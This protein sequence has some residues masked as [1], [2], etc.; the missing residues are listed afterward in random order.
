MSSEEL[1]NYRNEVINKLK[2]QAVDRVNE[3][4]KNKFTGPKAWQELIKNP[5]YYNKLGGLIQA[6]KGKTVKSKDGTVTNT[7]TKANGDT[8]IQVKTKNGKYYEKLIKK[9]DALDTLSKLQGAIKPEFLA[10]GNAEAKTKKEEK[11][12]KQKFLKEAWSNYDDWST[13][14]KVSDRVG[15]FLND[16]F[17]MTARALTGDQAYIPG[18]AQG[19]HNHEDPEVRNRYLK[20]LGYTPGEFDASDV[21]NMINPGYW[22]SSFVENSRKGNVG[23]AALEGALMFLPHLPKGT[24]SKSNIRSGANML[25]NDVAKEYNKVA[26]GNSF[27]TDMGVPAWKIEK[28]NQS[29]FGTGKDLR[30]YIAKNAT[31]R[32]AELYT[33]FGQGMHNLTPEDWAEFEAL[34]K[35]GATDFS[36][37]NTPISRIPL[38]YNSSEKAWDEARKLLNLKRGQ[39]YKTPSNKSIRTWSAGIPEGYSAERIARSKPE[40]KIRLVI[41]SR[42]TKNLGNEFA[43]MPYHDPKVKF[44]Y[45]E[46]GTINL[47]AASENELM[48][49][50]PGGFKVIGKSAEDGMNNLIIKPVNNSNLFSNILGKLNKKKGYNE[51][52]KQLFGSDNFSNGVNK[53]ID[54]IPYKPELNTNAAS[55]LY[56]VVHERKLLFDTPEGKRRIQEIIDNTP[57]IKNAGITVDDYKKGLDEI[58]NVNVHYHNLYKKYDDL[59]KALN[60]GKS[61]PGADLQALNDMNSQLGKMA[62]ELG[63]YEEFIHKPKWYLNA[64]LQ[65]EQ[66]KQNALNI[67][68]SVEH[69]ML[70][71]NDKFQIFTSPWLSDDDILRIGRHEIGHY[72]QRGVKTNLD[73]ELEKITLLESNPAIKQIPAGQEK[74]S[75]EFY[76]KILSKEDPFYSMKKYWKTGSKGRETVPFMEEVRADLLEEGMINNLYDEVTTEMLEYHYTNYLKKQGNKYPLRIFDIMENKPENFKIMSDVINKMPAIAPIVG[77]AGAAAI[78]GNEQGQKKEM[79]KGG[80]VADLTEKEIREY[81]ARGYIVEEDD[82]EYQD[83]GE[84]EAISNIRRRQKEIADLRA[85]SNMSEEVNQTSTQAPVQKTIVINKEPIKPLVRIA[86]SN[87]QIE[88]PKS[89]VVNKPIVK[90]FEKSK[91]KAEQKLNQKQIIHQVQAIKK[92]LKASYLPNAPKEFYNQFVEKPVTKHVQTPK[93]L[94]SDN[95]TYAD[96]LKRMMRAIEEDDMM[97]LVSGTEP[98]PKPLFENS[99]IEKEILDRQK[100]DNTHYGRFDTRG[101][102][103]MNRTDVKRNRDSELFFANMAKNNSVI[104]DIGSALGNNDPKLSGVSVFEL[105]SNPKIKHQ[106]NDKKIVEIL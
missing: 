27:L 62:I 11:Q 80:I 34:T 87:K 59:E 43:A 53:S 9:S 105:A 6:Q 8:V 102:D 57:E 19:L 50:I 68:K 88:K 103:V 49:N 82:D 29:I 4:L 74:G 78:M 1:L 16:P 72:V 61:V 71:P 93:A 66:A 42:Y 81:T 85:N 10:L 69:K 2:K 60:Y 101:D 100:F 64:Y 20:E 37:V 21:Q 54:A 99:N 33:K 13:S 104:V 94:H 18:M 75:S 67:T 98:K 58:T 70:H 86:V 40:Q 65:R 48:G 73:K 96:E 91:V 12:A 47:N 89:T 79:K 38:Y 95:K 45:N 28:P 51:V 106:N 52:S 55:K 14:D 44:V 90:T 22:A 30:T 56:K 35:S 15:A 31:D 41:P 5:G 63:K 83:G 7:I 92:D 77:G 23:T 24:V 84:A 97:A 46:D 32:E 25:K 39:I 76:N 3:N 36:K 26:T 17:G